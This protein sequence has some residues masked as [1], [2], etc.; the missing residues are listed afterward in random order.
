MTTYKY[1]VA[2]YQG[3]IDGLEDW[4]NERGQEGWSLAE[5]LEKTQTQSGF[6]VVTLMNVLCIFMCE[7]K[8]EVHA[9]FRGEFPFP[10]QDQIVDKQQAIKYQHFTDAISKHILGF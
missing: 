2:R 6:H 8:S 9:T 5:V 10:Q 1:Q 4:L 3:G 7:I